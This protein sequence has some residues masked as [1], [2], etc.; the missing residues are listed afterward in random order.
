MTAG[1]FIQA[2]GSGLYAPAVYEGSTRLIEP[3]GLFIQRGVWTVGASAGSI[4]ITF[5]IPFNASNTPT[6]MAAMR[7]GSRGYIC[8]TGGQNNT[9]MSIV[10]GTNGGAVP[11]VALSGDW[12]AVG[13]R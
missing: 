9:V 13:I 3:A 6:C 12:L 7:S 11:T 8:N 4:T 2:G 1:G 10:V 5:P